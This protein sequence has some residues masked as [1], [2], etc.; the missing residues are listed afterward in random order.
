MSTAAYNKIFK[1]L[2]VIAV[3][4]VI[5]DIIY[6]LIG[7][8]AFVLWPIILIFCACG[9]ALQAVCGKIVSPHRDMRVGYT[10][11]TGYEEYDEPFSPLRAAFSLTVCAV[12]SV[13]LYKPF[14]L[15]LLAASKSM[16]GVVYSENSL[17]PIILVVFA[18]IGFGSGVVLWFY[19]AHRIIS[20]RTMFTFIP[21]F[22]IVFLA[23]FF[24]DRDSAPMSVFLAVFAFCALIVLNQTHIQRSVNDTVTAISGRGRRYNLKLMMF[25][26]LVFLFLLLVISA[27]VVGVSKIFR[28]IAALFLASSLN[29]EAQQNGLPGGYYT[30][31]GGSYEEL[32]QLFGKGE[33]VG[34]RLLFMLFILLFI[35]GV[36]FLIM[37]GTETVKRFLAYAKEWLSNVFMFLM[38]AWHFNARL[39]PDDEDDFLNY[40]DEEIKLQH[41]DINEYGRKAPPR[42]NSYRDFMAKL[43]AMT[44]TEERIRFA[45]TTM[46][47]SYRS[48]GMGNR[49]ADTPREAR[50][51]VIKKTGDGAVSR[52][53]DA[54]EAIDYREAELSEE[55]GRRVILDMCGVIEKHFDS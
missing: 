32:A 48:R 16:P 35:G 54:I 10:D 4:S 29:Q 50:D 6:L 5:S 30:D 20:L 22:W 17:I 39:D 47:A 2:A 53:T 51:V 37:R 46:M 24:F 55:A 12:I 42:A 9:Y 40:R 3:S 36:A 18:F 8:V 1:L 45:Y 43:N 21:A 28:F 49:V 19:P 38:N 41:A 27:V 26:V 31:Q 33:P 14:D 44:T 25:V 7:H 23:S 13:L 52:A 11:E 15:L 34:E